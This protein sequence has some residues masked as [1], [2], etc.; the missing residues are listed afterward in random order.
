MKEPWAKVF[1]APGSWEWLWQCH[2]P[3]LSCKEM[4]LSA[5]HEQGMGPLRAS[6]AECSPTHPLSV[7]THSTCE[8][9]SVEW[10]AR[11]EALC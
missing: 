2:G 7:L 8:R 5:P 10:A 3:E 11:S 9:P 6:W 1:W 4:I